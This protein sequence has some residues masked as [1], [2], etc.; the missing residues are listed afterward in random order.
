MSKHYNMT[1]FSILFSMKQVLA[2][3]ATQGLEDQEYAD[4]AFHDI[5]H[6]KDGLAITALSAHTTSV[7][8][9]MAAML[10]ADFIE[11]SGSYLDVGV[12]DP[13][14]GE[15]RLNTHPTV[16][17]MV[18]LFRFLLLMK[19]KGDPRCARVA[20]LLNCMSHQ[21]NCVAAAT[22]ARGLRQGMDVEAIQAPSDLASQCP[23]EEV[24]S[25]FDFP[26]KALTGS[27]IGAYPVEFA[28]GAPEWL[29]AGLPSQVPLLFLHNW[30]VP[31]DAL[32][33]AEAVLPGFQ[34]AATRR[35]TIRRG[36]RVLTQPVV[37]LTGW[38]SWVS[39]Q[40][41]MDYG[42]DGSIFARM[43]GRAVASGTTF[44]GTFYP[45]SG[46]L[47]PQTGSERSIEEAIQDLMKTET[48]LS[49]VLRNR[50]FAR[51]RMGEA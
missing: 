7:D 17:K 22:L 43:L 28:P 6:S 40:N 10:K 1:T 41:H 47:C 14:T 31:A 42:A 30:V 32:E 19:H 4:L 37:A 16:V 46:G 24:C 49:L 50:V 21:A 34:I 15:S 48:P 20:G 38:G 2:I 33:D 39:G 44:E 12:I 25:G 45:Q 35:D 5:P 51:A 26:L 27:H 9:L 13:Q 11:A 36:G 23:L 8:D 18:D 29:Q 3:N